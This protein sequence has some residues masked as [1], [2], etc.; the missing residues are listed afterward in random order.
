MHFLPAGIKIS[1]FS[2]NISGKKMK[3]VWN[4]RFD[5]EGFAYGKEPNVFFREQLWE[6]KFGRVLLPAEG[7]GRDAVYAAKRG[8]LVHAVDFSE[9]AAAKAIQFANSEGVRIEY[10]ISDLA[11]FETAQDYYHLISVSFLHL[12]PEQR[13]HFHRK[14]IQSLVPGGTFIAE[15]FSIKQLPLNTGGPKNPLMLYT[16]E[17]LRTDFEGMDFQILSEELREMENGLYHFDA[18]WVIR[19]KALKPCL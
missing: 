13:K 8:W 5:T 19:V 4:Q 6:K 3:E 18:S 10:Q 7:E 12:L 16:L 1:G 15:Y 11:S 17:D 2:R 9:V 14:M